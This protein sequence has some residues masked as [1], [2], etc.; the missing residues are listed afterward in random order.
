MFETEQDLVSDFVASLEASDSPWGE[1]SYALEFFYHRGRTDVIAISEEGAVIAFEAKLNRWR[2]AVQQAYRNT[3]FAHM[4]YVVLPRRIAQVAS[5]YAYEFLSRRIGLCYVEGGRITIVHE[6]PA[7]NP[8]QPWLSDQ[9]IT[10][11]MSESANG[12]CSA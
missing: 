8:I 10:T 6:A 4:S 12:C 1:V 5:V 11:V 3:C 9:A 7:Q 2:D